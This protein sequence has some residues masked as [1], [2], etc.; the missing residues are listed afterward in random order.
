MLIVVSD[1]QFR[2]DEA[3]H[4]NAMFDEGLQIFH[5]R[6][7]DSNAA[8]IVELLRKIDSRHHSKIS[9]H[10]HY[11]LASEFGIS[12]IHH[13]EKIRKSIRDDEL[14]LLNQ[15][16]FTLS[17]SIH[18][19]KEE[20]SQSYDYVFFGPVFNSISKRGY[21]SKFDQQ[22]AVSTC[23]VKRFAIGGVDERNCSKALQM[24][25]DGVAILGAIWRSN[26][27]IASFKKIQSACQ[28]VPQY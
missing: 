21:H 1:V 4:I 28:A 8:A 23:A 22:S 24:G 14:L 19:T 18:K 13:P 17:T 2:N 25:F 16:C 6:K 27:V 26:D 20:V 5:L 12:R 3:H 11:H 15:S 9:L 7:P 10:Q